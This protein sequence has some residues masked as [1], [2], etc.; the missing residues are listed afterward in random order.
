MKHESQ[1]DIQSLSICFFLMNE[2]SLFIVY[3]YPENQHTSPQP[4]TTT[5]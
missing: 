4:G 5:F 2:M 3:I 1:Q